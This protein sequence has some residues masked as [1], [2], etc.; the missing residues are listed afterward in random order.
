[1][2]ENMGIF[3]LAGD[4]ARHATD[5]QNHIAR[6]VANADTPGYHATDLADFA[7]T[8]D[9]GGVEL[10]ATR[11]GHFT[12]GGDSASSAHAIKRDSEASPN[13]NTV[14]LEDEML[15]AADVRRQ[16]DMALT[17]YANARDVLRT[18]LGRG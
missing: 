17:I 4:L 1:M 5:R 12:E 10:R 9:R 8:L 2:I 16:H 11:P 3:R 18:S 13:G 6:N 14:S 7:S 15:Q